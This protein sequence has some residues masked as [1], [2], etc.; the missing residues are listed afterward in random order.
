MGTIRTIIDIIV[1]RILISSLL[2]SVLSSALLWFPVSVSGRGVLSDFVCTV[3][4][5]RGSVKLIAIK[6]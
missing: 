4:F 5:V 1:C 6:L 2:L 3:R